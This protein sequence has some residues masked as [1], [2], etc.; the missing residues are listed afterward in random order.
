MKLNMWLQGVA[1]ATA[2]SVVAYLVIAPRPSLAAS[3]YLQEL[4]VEAARSENEQAES[5]APQGA[6]S[7]WSPKQQTLSETI[8]AGLSME[9]FEERLKQS[10]YGSYLFY[11]TLEEREQQRVYADYQQDNAIESIRESIK[12]NMKK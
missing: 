1:L 5:T 11:S 12:S 7:D 2:F 3:S 8:E 10:F 4:E 6:G 9:Q